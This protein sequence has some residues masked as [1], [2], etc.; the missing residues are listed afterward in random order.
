MAYRRRNRLVKRNG[1]TRVR[2]TGRGLKGVTAA[3]FRGAYPGATVFSTGHMRTRRGTKRRMPMPTATRLKRRRTAGGS[4]GGGEISFLKKRSGYKKRQT[5]N[6]LQLLSMNKILYRFQGVNR[7]NNVSK[8]AI[9]ADGTATLACP[10]FYKLDNSPNA[11]GNQRFPLHVY[12]LTQLP[13]NS[14]T[15]AVS[16]RMEIGDTGAILWTQQFGQKTDGTGSVDAAGIS[17]WELE[18]NTIGNASL[19]QLN[20]RYAQH[21]W[22]DI[23]LC[24]YGARQQPTFYDIML[25]SFTRDYLQPCNYTTTG[26]P[27]ETQA[28]GAFWASMVKNISYNAILPGAKDAFKGMTVHKR[29]RF[30]HQPSSTTEA[31]RNPALKIVKYFHKDYKIRDYNWGVTR[32]AADTEVNDADYVQNPAAG[33]VRNYPKDK[34]RLFLIVR[35]SNTTPVD[36]ATS[37]SDNTPSYD[38]VIRKQVRVRE[39]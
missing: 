20:Q 9:A 32:F 5:V 14:T 18:D 35:A 17:T 7:M 22:F 15:T 24:A 33:T 29:F 27:E 2:R 19:Y 11:V 37:N 36:P 25:V 26:D 16:Y 12:D 3:G 38:L 30:V 6:K 8:G 34:Q 28:Y 10:G 4:G 1:R 21:D 13:Q 23:R 31:D 39:A